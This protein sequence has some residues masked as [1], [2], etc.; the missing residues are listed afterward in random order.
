MQGSF[1]RCH[2]RR[3]GGAVSQPAPGLFLDLVLHRSRARAPCSRCSHHS[4][5]W[6]MHSTLFLFVKAFVL[7][8]DMKNLLSWLASEARLRQ[9]KTSTRATIKHKARE[10][11]AEQHRQ[12]ESGVNYGTGR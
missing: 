5:G 3:R 6:F 4:H 2:E 8:N 12:G 10:M 7:K 1:D 11:P 9:T